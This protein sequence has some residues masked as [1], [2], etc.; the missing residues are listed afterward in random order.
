VFGAKIAASVI[1]RRPEFSIV[2]AV[3]AVTLA[4]TS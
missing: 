4:G 2:A 3:T 1:A